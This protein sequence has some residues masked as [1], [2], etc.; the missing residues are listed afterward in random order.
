MAR[1]SGGDHCSD[2][3]GDS[4]VSSKRKLDANP[5][6]ESQTKVSVKQ[7]IPTDSPS[8]TSAFGDFMGSK[9][10]VNEV[11]KKKNSDEDRFLK[12]SGLTHGGSETVVHPLVRGQSHNL[13]NVQ[14]NRFADKER[15]QLYV[16]EICAGSA[17]LS[18]A[19][20]EMGFMV[21]PIDHKTTRSCGVPI[22]VWDLEDPQQLQLLLDFLQEEKDNIL[23]VWMAPPCGTA[24]RARERRQPKLEAQGVKVPVPLRSTVQPDQLD[25][26][27][28][29]DKVKTEKANILYSAIHDIAVLCHSLDL[30]AVIENP[31]N[32][33]FWSTTPMQ[34]LN[35]S[36][37]SHSWVS[38]H[39]CCHGGD[40]DKLTSL[41][42]NKPWLND[43]EARC[44]GKHS[45]KSWVPSKTPD[46]VLFPTSEEA[47]YPTILC[48]RIISMMA[49]Q[50]EAMGANMSETLQQQMDVGLDTAT[51]RIVL[52]CLP[53]GN[54]VKPLVAEY[55]HYIVALCN[56]QDDKTVDKTIQSLPKGAKIVTRRIVNGEH[57]RDKVLESYSKDRIVVHYNNFPL[58]LCTIGVPSGPEEFIRRAVEA[59]HPRSLDGFVDEV[60]KVAAY[61]NF[62]G[63]PFDLAKKRLNFFKRWNARALEL[64]G[65]ERAYKQ[66]LPAH[67]AEVLSGKRLLIFKE[68]LESIDYPDKDLVQQMSRGFELSGWLPKSNV[69]LPGSRRPSFDKS[70]MMKLAKGLNRATLSSLG[71]RQE[72]LLE[73]G[74]WDETI[75]EL[76]NGWLW[77]DKSCDLSQHVVAKRFGIKQGGKIR[78]I[79][80]CS[81][82]GLNGSVGLKEKFKLH[83]VDQLASMIAY[84]FGVSGQRHPPLLGRTYDLKSAYKQF[85]VCCEDRRLLRIAVNEPGVAQPRIMGVNVL[86]FGA[87]GS[88]A[89]FLRISVAIWYV[90][91]RCLGLFWS[92][93]YDDF[94]V[95]T[96]VELQQNTAWA[97]EALFNLLG[98]KF[99]NS[100]AKYIP[101][102]EKFKMLGLMMDLSQSDQKKIFLGH[103]EERAAELGEQLQMHLDSGKMSSKEAERLRGRMLFYESFTFGRLSGEAIKAVGRLACGNRPSVVFRGDVKQSL[104][105]LLGRVTSA[106]PIAVTQKQRM[107]VYFYRWCL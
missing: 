66:T 64:C 54:K 34:K 35:T 45:H 9:T 48:T 32:S 100:G 50:A 84:S 63:P 49:I 105:F 72:Q 67:C 5:V 14:S 97:C 19:A 77:E 71:Q 37:A 85:P 42:V 107:L 65:E 26:L 39:N 78:V 30:F 96:R 2:K 92:S 75:K 90:G 68:I 23:L 3:G 89:A 8:V 27:Q 106:S 70:T 102:A 12:D 87:V 94:S 43:L 73:Q 104:E 86:P 4:G 40:R 55:D 91:I 81:C 15:R 16:V 101:F 76:D 21:L 11:L 103:T 60:V 88:V 46:G 93:F 83:S 29:T 25:G 56:P 80:D 74:A 36:V 38:F 69:F 24:S 6:G 62:H 58:E 57:D 53:R 33:H 51:N 13:C 59:G 95:V 20:L 98:M 99:A 31:F 82:C 61:D 44:D 22:Q 17:K 41:W 18:K 79:D 47:A 28:G 1:S 52:G 7:R 10:D